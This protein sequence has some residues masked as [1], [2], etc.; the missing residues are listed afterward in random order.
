[1]DSGRKTCIDGKL[2]IFYIDRNPHLNLILYVFSTNRRRH[3]IPDDDDR[4]FNVAYAAVTR[5]QHQGNT[6]KPKVSKLDSLQSSQLGGY[7]VS[8]G[9]RQRPLNAGMSQVLDVGFHH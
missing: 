2:Y 1:M 5:K 8:I 3:G 6:V 9:L 4:P 7:D